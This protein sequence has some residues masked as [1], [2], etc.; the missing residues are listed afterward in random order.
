MN[1][2]EATLNQVWTHKKK[3]KKKENQHY[4]NKGYLQ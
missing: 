2:S 4:K 1:T 3:K